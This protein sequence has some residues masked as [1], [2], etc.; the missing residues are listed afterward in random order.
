MDIIA[1]SDNAITETQKIDI[2]SS[3][4]NKKETSMLLWKLKPGDFDSWL[5]SHKNKSQPIFLLISS[6]RL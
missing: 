1:I 4:I 3:N 2:K 5:E 6:I